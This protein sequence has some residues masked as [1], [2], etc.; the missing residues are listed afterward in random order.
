MHNASNGERGAMSQQGAGNA[1]EGPPV[2]LLLQQWQAGERGA[3]DQLIPLIYEELR[4]LAQH[5]V[6]REFASHTLQATA[7]VNEAWLRLAQQSAGDFQ[8]R[9]QF[10]GA[11][12]R[13]MRQ[14]LVDHARSRLAKKRGG[15]AVRVPLEAVQAAA[16]EKDVQLLALDQALS[17]LAALDPEQAQLVELRYFSG[18][19][20]EETAQVMGM[21]PATVKRH[22]NT[23]RAWL[24]QQ[25]A[26]GQEG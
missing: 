9:T 23:A 22:W 6:A 14:I 25:L 7:L 4:R 5:H 18:L 24:K 20:I 26:Q 16:Q 11:A 8:S 10:Y 13:L 17:A 1:S 3:L 12:A 19:S 2:T 15:G 21:S